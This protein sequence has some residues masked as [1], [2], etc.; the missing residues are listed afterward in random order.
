MSYNENPFASSHSLDTNPFDDPATTQQQSDATR[1]EELRQ[2][3]A[4]LERRERE[5]ARGEREN[6]RAGVRGRTCRVRNTSRGEG[7]QLELS[8]VVAWQTRKD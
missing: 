7:G 6:E 5:L 4:D 3:E 1:L 8:K 2:R